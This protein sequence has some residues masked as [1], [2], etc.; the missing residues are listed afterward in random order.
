M[1]TAAA[2]TALP[3]LGLAVPAAAHDEDATLHWENY[4]KITLT[5][6]VGEPIDLAVLPDNR[7][8]HTARSGEVR[9]TDPKTGVTKVVN[10]I[11]VYQNS[12][13]GLQT[14]TLDPGFAENHWVYLY[15]SPKL[16]TPA[17]SAPTRCPRARTTRTGSSG[18]A[19]TSCRGSSGP[20]SRWT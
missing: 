4:E 8:L 20:A 15:Y 16:N 3:V 5:K 13:M 17:G 19:T 10:T 11:P 18:R 9:L 6:N 1:I 2:V 12:E 7:V 14:V